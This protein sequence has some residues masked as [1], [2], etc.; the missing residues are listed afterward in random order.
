LE[1]V[2]IWQYST[3]H[4]IGVIH[5]NIISAYRTVLGH[6][7]EYQWSVLDIIIPRSW[8][9]RCFQQR[10]C[11]TTVCIFNFHLLPF[12]NL[13]LFRKQDFLLM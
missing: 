13:I 7:E 6:F 8:R 9:C 1:T 5:V 3:P 11:H 4:C 2:H 10:Q 12:N